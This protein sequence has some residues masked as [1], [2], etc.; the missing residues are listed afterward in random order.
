MNNQKEMMNL[1]FTINDAYFYP[2]LVV[3]KSIILTNNSNLIVIHLFYQSLSERNL[4]RLDYFES[5]N[6]IEVQ[7]NVFT[8][9][10]TEFST[11]SG[12]HESSFIRLFLPYV[13]DL[14]RYLYL[15]ADV[16]IT[17]DISKLYYMDLKNFPI[18][19]TIQPG[20]F[21]YRKKIGLILKDENRYFMSGVLLVSVS[22]YREKIL[23]ERMLLEL[24]RIIG[25]G[26][27]LPDMD[28]L[29]SIVE[30]EFLELNSIYH[31][32]TT[33]HYEVT[34][35]I[36]HYAGSTKPWHFFYQGFYKS[37]Y[38]RIRKEI[39]FFYKRLS[40]NSL[41]QYLYSNLPR[42]MVNIYKKVIGK[43]IN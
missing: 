42:A 17:G 24:R 35:L 36:L 31:N 29:N 11:N 30:N 28:T 33:T 4:N 37:E 8:E 15:D 10:L 20:Y 12:W 41:K 13:L 5:K 6:K 2:F 16:L 21:D 27:L 43:N 34:P 25:N 18:A 39:P 1:V 40:I 38:D 23:L 7:R 32:T 3:I 9:D 14:E 19:S 26:S 22:R